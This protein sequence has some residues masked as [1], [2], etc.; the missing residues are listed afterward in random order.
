MVGILKDIWLSDMLG[1]R[2]VFFGLT[3][4]RAMLQ[5]WL[6]LQNVLELA[7]WVL[8]AERERT[9]CLGPIMSDESRAYASSGKESCC[10][11]VIDTTSGRWELPV[12]EL[13]CL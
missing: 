8:T 2:V 9:V 13:V 6:N 3:G 11:T 12:R 1:A 4:L 10:E 5:D 7:S